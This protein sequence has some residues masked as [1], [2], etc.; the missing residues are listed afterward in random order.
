MAIQPTPPIQLDPSMDAGHQLAFI[1]Q[2]FQNIA[3]VL[4]QNSFVILASGT[5]TVV[6]PTPFSSNSV[7]STS[8]AHNLGFK[9]AYIAFVDIPIGDGSAL[10]QGKLTNVPASLLA[11]GG[12]PGV[13]TVRAVADVDTTNINFRVENPGTGLT[14]VDG[15]WVFKYYLVQQTASTS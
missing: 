15:N 10:L 13:V 1:N 12:T 3:N 9:P 7:K 14:G 4:Q 11:T 6:V 8:V 5:A 2:N